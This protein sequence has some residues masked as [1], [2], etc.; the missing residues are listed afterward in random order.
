MQLQLMLPG[1]TWQPATT[2]LPPD[3]A[4]CSVAAVHTDQTASLIL[5]VKQDNIQNNKSKCV[6][7]WMLLIIAD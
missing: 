4:R 7:V 5:Y 2:V 3:Q 6:G 1:P